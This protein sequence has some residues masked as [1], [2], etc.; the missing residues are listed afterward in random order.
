M[1]EFPVKIDALLAPLLTATTDEHADE[2]LSQ[3]LVEHAEPALKGVIRFKLR[4]NSRH[5]RVL[6]LPR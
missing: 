5:R 4:F 6:L 2:L 3:V 1:Q